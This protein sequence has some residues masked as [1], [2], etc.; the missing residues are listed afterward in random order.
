MLLNMGWFY[1]EYVRI[2]CREFGFFDD[3]E[4][5]VVF[6][7]FLYFRL[8]DVKDIS[9]KYIEI[10]ERD[11]K[12]VVFFVEEV[13]EMEYRRKGIV[14]ENIRFLFIVNFLFGFKIGKYYKIVMW[15]W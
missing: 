6:K 1:F 3:F 15:K 11:F 2:V 7:Y 10:V 5:F 12:L 14:E 13:R 4:Y 9:S 8:F